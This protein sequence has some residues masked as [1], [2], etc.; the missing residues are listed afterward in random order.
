MKPA[1]FLYF[2]PE[3]REEV[4]ALLVE[5]GDEARPLA[6]GQSLV[7]AMNFRLA[8]PTALVD[9]NRVTELAWIADRGERLAL[10]AMTRQALAEHSPLVATQAP[11]L[12]AALQWVAHPQI[13]NRGTVGGSLAHGD[14]AAELPAVAIALGARLHLV[15]PQGERSVPASEFYRGLFETALEQGEIVDSVDFEG[16]W[17]GWGFSELS[18]RHGDFALAGVAAVLRTDPAGVVESVRCVLF[19]VGDIPVEVPEAPALLVGQVVTTALID[20]VAEAALGSVDP[21]SDLHASSAYRRH[22]V[23]VLVRRSLSAAVRR[24]ATGVAAHG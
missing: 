18:R 9:L 14:P 21:P 19:A 23:G 12:S 10:G 2:A 24:S 4:V 7:P 6:G 15:G 5:H 16:G 3:N 11:L 8:R 1:P 20:A 13:R 22:L 17:S